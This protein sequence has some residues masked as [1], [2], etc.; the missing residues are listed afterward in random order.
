MQSY[1]YFN[2]YAYIC[3]QKNDMTELRHYEVVAGVVE[4][5]GRVMCLRKGATRY[6]YT[7]NRWEFPGGKIEPGETPEQALQR[8]LLEELRLHV[9][10][11]DHLTTVR[12]QYPDFGITLH[13]YHCQAADEQVQLLEHEQVA[14]V[15]PERLLDLQWCAADV[16]IAQ[17]MAEQ[18]NKRQ[19]VTYS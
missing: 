2:D 18:A 5:Q 13:A 3:N 4:H 16:P 8:E 12:H 10:V 11:G 7:S 1:N 17:C 15:E 6:A 9:E 14:W 19:S